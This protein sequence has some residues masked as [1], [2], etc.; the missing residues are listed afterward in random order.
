MAGLD[1]GCSSGR[2]VRVLAAAYPELDWHG[3]DP[4]P[5]AIEWARENLPGIAFEQSPEYPPLPYAD[6]HSTSC[7]RSRSGA[8]SRRAPRSTGCARCAASSGRAGGSLLTTH[9]AQTISHTQR[10]GVRSPEQLSEVR[11]SAPRRRFLVRGRVRRAGRPWRRQSRL[12]HG[13]RD[14]RVV[15]C[16]AHARLARGLFRPGRVEGNQDLYVLERR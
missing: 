7:S 15:A 14:P 13:V 11:D 9:G 12:G 3:C 10:E 1:F 6:G 16:E 4:I 2:V 8:T 5:D